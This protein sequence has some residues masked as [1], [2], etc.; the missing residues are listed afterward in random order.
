M[1]QYLGVDI[2]EISRVEESVARWGNGFL[3]RVFTQVEKE[4]Y[5]GKIE[6]LAV[7]FAAKEAAVKALGCRKI[8]YRDIEILSESDGRPSLKLHG[9]ALTIAGSLGI[10]EFAVSLSHDRRNAVAIVSA[11]V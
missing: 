9:R 5:K 10:T 6:S 7:R 8:I 3:D 4:L 2:I 11:I 1:K